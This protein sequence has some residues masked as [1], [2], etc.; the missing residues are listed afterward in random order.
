MAPLIP[1][2]VDVNW[3]GGLI[4][5]IKNPIPS[6]TAGEPKGPVGAG[7]IGIGVFRVYAG[8][9]KTLPGGGGDDDVKSST[10]L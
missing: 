2:T 3:I 5:N 10:R 8:S 4:N 9:T 7:D 6:P 1:P